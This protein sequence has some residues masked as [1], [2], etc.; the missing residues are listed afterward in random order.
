M[1]R[2]LPSKQPEA[3]QIRMVS[4]VAIENVVQAYACKLRFSYAF[5]VS[6]EGGASEDFRSAVGKH[7]PRQNLAVLV[8][9]LELFMCVG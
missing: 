8:Q 7:A 1:R 3:T 2:R 9:A 6:A 4:S 5:S